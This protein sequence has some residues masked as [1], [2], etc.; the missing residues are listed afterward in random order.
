MPADAPKSPPATPKNA[1]ASKN[2]AAPKNR[3]AAPKKI[4]R[5]AYAMNYVFQVTF[6]LLMP[7]GLMLL[8]GRWLTGRCGLGRWAMAVCII[9]GV[10]FGFYNMFYFI[11]KTAK[12]VD[13]TAPNGEEHDRGR[14]Q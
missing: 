13:P 9:V 2:I 5:A 1:D 6:S 7:A 3:S 12:H 10:L 4:F 8:L 11:V 14:K